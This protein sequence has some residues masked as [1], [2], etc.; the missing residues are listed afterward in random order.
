M[1]IRVTNFS[2][3]K[4]LFYRK[5]RR[6]Y[7]NSWDS[8]CKMLLCCVNSGS[9]K[10]RVSFYFDGKNAKIFLIY[11]YYLFNMFLRCLKNIFRLHILCICGARNGF[12]KSAKKCLFFIFWQFFGK[13]DDFSK[14]RSAF[15]MRFTLKNY[16][17][18][19]EFGKT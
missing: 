4:F 11:Y 5:V 6:A 13:I 16:Q 3:L 10:G 7:Q 14:F 15:G 12:P 8:R 18:C 17:I 1:I 19:Q 9:G 2:S